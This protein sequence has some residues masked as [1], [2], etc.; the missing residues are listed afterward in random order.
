[1]RGCRQ[2]LNTWNYRHLRPHMGKPIGP[3]KRVDLGEAWLV[4]LDRMA[5][6]AGERIG[7]NFRI[8]KEP[9]REDPFQWDVSLG[10]CDT[11]DTLELFGIRLMNMGKKMMG[12]TRVPSRGL[13]GLGIRVRAHMCNVAGDNFLSF[14]E[15]CGLYHN[16][17]CVSSKSEWDQVVEELI[18]MGVIPTRWEAARPAHML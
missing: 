7:A 16:L 2:P 3:S 18:K 15:A 14:K 8:L 17:S 6:M 5:E 11:T 4:L 12:K 10:L 13:L 1:M 9:M